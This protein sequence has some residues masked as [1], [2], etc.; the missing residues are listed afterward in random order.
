MTATFDELEHPR[1]ATGQFADKA[2]GAPEVSLAAA[3]EKPVLTRTQKE[4]LSRLQQFGTLTHL[5]RGRYGF[6]Q[7]A[8]RAGG[9]KTLDALVD[10]GYAVHV[11]K[12]YHH[13]AIELP[14][15]P[16][17][18]AERSASD[19]RLAAQSREQ[20]QAQI[21]RAD[22]SLHAAAAAHAENVLRVEFPEA[23]EAWFIESRGGY[24]LSEVRAGDDYL[25]WDKEAPAVRTLEQ[26]IVP[27]LSSYSGD[28]LE[29]I[30]AGGRTIRVTIR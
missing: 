9:T 10:M 20:L 16:E 28:H 23:T 1:A 27:Q 6:G 24:A 21:D 12:P 17:R 30:R 2:Q 4:T 5:A 11:N 29:H 14:P 26:D 25:S 7:D 15:T 8:Q 3:P 22:R 18:L 19:L 13:Y